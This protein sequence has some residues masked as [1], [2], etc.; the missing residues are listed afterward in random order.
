MWRRNGTETN[1][2]AGSSKSQVSESQCGNV[3]AGFVQDGKKR[4]NGH[5]NRLVRQAAMAMDKKL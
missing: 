5:L 2:G 1:N 4:E 3:S